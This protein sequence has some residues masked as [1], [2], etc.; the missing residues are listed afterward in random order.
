MVCLF[1]AYTTSYVLGK[2]QIYYYIHIQNKCQWRSR[3]RNTKFI[4]NSLFKFY[5]DN[6]KAFSAMLWAY[7]V[8][9]H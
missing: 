6:E 3:M 2:P 1:T 7:L 8:L 5:I 9:Y 4:I